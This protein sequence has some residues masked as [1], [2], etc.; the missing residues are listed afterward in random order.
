LLLLDEPSAGLSPKAADLLFET[1]VAVHQ[2]GTAIAM[3]EQNAR[4]ALAIA[5]RGVVL[6]DGRVA[7]AG[8]ARA[9]ADDPDIGR[10]FLGGT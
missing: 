4:E 6:V 1:I 10:L 7:H 3:V 5:D 9:M 8:V 2:S